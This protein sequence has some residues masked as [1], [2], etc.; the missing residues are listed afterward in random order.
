MIGF[1]LR[2]PHMQSLDVLIG[3]G[4][5]LLVLSLWAEGPASGA[6]VQELKGPTDWYEELTGRSRAQITPVTV[7]C[8]RFIGG[9][10][11]F[12]CVS[13]CKL[14]GVRVESLFLLS[15]LPTPHQSKRRVY[16][17]C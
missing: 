10:A 5:G 2:L 12:V 3:V 8:A 17:S 16:H 11:E 13:H 7:G 9:K 6:S 1:F 14:A 15:N 4:M